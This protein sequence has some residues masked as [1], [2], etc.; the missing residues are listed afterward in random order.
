MFTYVMMLAGLLR[1]PCGLVQ[2]LSSDCWLYMVLCKH[3][4]HIMRIEVSTTE[5][6]DGFGK[7]A[8]ALQASIRLDLLVM[9]GSIVRHVEN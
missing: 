5:V 6:C 4:G 1:V 3:L 2:S 7:S 8:R 9:D